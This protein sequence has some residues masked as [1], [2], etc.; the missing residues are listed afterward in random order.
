M[1]LE[2]AYRESLDEL[3]YDLDE[4]YQLDNQNMNH[5]IGNCTGSS[6]KS[7]MT[8]NKNL[9]DISESLIDSL[10][11]FELPAWG[12]GLKYKFGTFK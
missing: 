8:F 5:H 1:N 11:T 9:Q 3:G 7:S 2:I 12:Y 6:S 10:A 4:I